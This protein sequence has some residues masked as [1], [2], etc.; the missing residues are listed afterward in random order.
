LTPD[1][2]GLDG[3]VTG[4]RHPNGTGSSRATPMG[5]DHLDLC[6]QETRYLI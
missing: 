4:S 6:R 5:A 2:T 1:V 3:S